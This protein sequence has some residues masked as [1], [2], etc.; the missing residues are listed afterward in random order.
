MSTDRIDDLLALAALGE[1]TDDDQRELDEAIVADPRL[2]DELDELLE[3]AAALQR[4]ADRTP[5][6][7]LRSRVLASVDAIEQEPGGGVLDDA[8][9]MAT[10]SSPATQAADIGTTGTAE[11]TDIGRSRRRGWVPL[12]AAAAVVALIVGGI[13]TLSIGDDGGGGSTFD[14]VVESDDAEVRVLD[15]EL[16]GSLAAI[17]SPAQ[18]ALALDGT[19]VPSLVD[20]TTYQL[21]LVDE[22]GATSVGL[23]RPDDTGRVEQRFDDVNPLGFVIGV[24]IEPA[25]GS[26]QPTPPIVA[27]A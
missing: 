19:D 13:L 27:K 1:L 3:T 24:T 8:P 4:S 10:G 26:D 11:V 14:A 2:A 6:P 22:A 5:P 9:T 15:G 21:W 12:A 16:S 18:S 7:D 20:N 25:G 23:F 17:Y